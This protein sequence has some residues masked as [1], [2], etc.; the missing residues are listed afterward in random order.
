MTPR[1]VAICGTASNTGKT[2]LLCDLLRALSRAEDWEA[3]KL[4]RG[5]Y[6]S[7]GKDPHACCVSGLLGEQ[8]TVRSGRQETYTFGK[9]TARYWDAGAANVHW[10]IATD[11]QVEAG[12]KEA[13]GRVK[14]PNVLIEGTSLLQVLPVDFAIMAVNGDAIRPKASVRRALVDRKINA[15]FLSNEGLDATHRQKILDSLSSIS[16]AIESNWLAQLPFFTPHNFSEITRACL[17]K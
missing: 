12:V 6:R 11:R 3:I 14:T 13:I 10:V 17:A 15:L 8:P 4:T 1:I 2:T 9:D 7:C 16:P 5:H